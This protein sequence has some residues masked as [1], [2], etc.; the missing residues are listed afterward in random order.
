MEK[1]VITALAG[2]LE[3]DGFARNRKSL[4][5]ALLERVFR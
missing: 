5:L 4:P 3:R 2:V 1:R